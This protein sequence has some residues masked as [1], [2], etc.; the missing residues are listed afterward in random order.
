MQIEVLILSGER[1]GSGLDF[2]QGSPVLGHFFQEV[3]DQGRVWGSADNFDK[4]LLVLGCG[5]LSG[6]CK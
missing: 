3:R 6:F 4:G 2:C 1:G 5:Y